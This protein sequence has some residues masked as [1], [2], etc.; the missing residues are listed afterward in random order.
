M[1]QKSPTIKEV[2]TKKTSQTEYFY[3][4]GRR[5]TAIAKIKLIFNSKIIH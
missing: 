3:G 5:K 1:A 2:K 4:L